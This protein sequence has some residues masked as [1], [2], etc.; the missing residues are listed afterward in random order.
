MEESLI[1]E[2]TAEIER[3]QQLMN[4]TIILI[5]AKQFILKKEI[6]TLRNVKEIHTRSEA[7]GAEA[8]T[9]YTKASIPQA[10]YT[11]VVDCNNRQRTYEDTRRY[12]S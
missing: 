2:K 3:L 11:W 1:A 10:S 7:Q 9:E 8:R 4:E 5:E 12:N 6:N